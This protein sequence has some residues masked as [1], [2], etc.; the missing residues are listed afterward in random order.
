[1][2][3][4]EKMKQRGFVYFIVKK[5]QTVIIAVKNLSA[6]TQAEM[7]TDG[8]GSQFFYF[9]VALSHICRLPFL[10]SDWCYLRS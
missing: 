2:E 8:N 9:H 3:A 10:L 4:D 7:F 1:M 5:S 6:L